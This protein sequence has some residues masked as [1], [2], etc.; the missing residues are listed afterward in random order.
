[1]N[2]ARTLNLLMGLVLLLVFG[3]LLLKMRAVDIDGHNRLV[4]IL[5]QLKQV[6]SDWNVEVL[7]SKT[8]FN[9]SYD[10]V[11]GPLPRFE[12]LELA[13]REETGKVWQNRSLAYQQLLTQAADYKAT[14]E[15]KIAMIE[16]FKSQ[17]SILRN[18]SRFLPPATGELLETIDRSNLSPRA[19]AELADPLSAMLAG[20]MNYVLTPEEGLKRRVLERVASL[21]A[22]A[23]TAPQ[24]VKE[25][26]QLLLPHVETILREQDL[27][28][29]LL[30]D[31]IAMP[32]ALKLDQLT[33]IYVAEHKKLLLEQQG[34]RQWLIVLLIGYT[35]FLLALLSYV[36]WRLV[37]SHSALNL[38]NTGL[39]G[40]NRQLKESQMQLVQSEKMSALGQMVAGIAHEINTPLSYLKGTVE[41]LR[42]QIGGLSE[43]VLGSHKLTQMLRNRPSDQNELKSQFL[44]VESLTSEAVESRAMDDLDTLLQSSADGISQISEI[45]LNLKNFSRVDRARVDEYSVQDGLESTL[46]LAR[47]MLKNHVKIVRQYA[48][49]PKIRCS[50]SQ[51]NQVFLNLITNATQAIAADRQ[52][53]ITLRTVRDGDSGVR[54]E[55]QDTGAGIAPEVLPKIFDPFFTTK[56]V[57]EGTGLGLSIS[58]KIIEEHGGRILVDSEPGIGTVFSII[59]PIVGP[60][61]S[62]EEETEALAA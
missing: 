34:Y 11:A 12:S 38:A 8:G 51:I 20:V 53:T 48:E 59:L 47:N 16:R 42:E 61:V 6:D 13:L 62:S 52:G 50:P 37:R 4:G 24:E 45:V 54:V 43:M 35:T 39:V 1:M 25:Q 5:R 29:R 19:K 9:A 21:Q 55:I 17:N 33:D 57:G 28:E 14:M 58:Y 7:K 31:L 18:S 22:G 15:R 41:L 26:V 30:A 49:V 2:N 32:T 36:G 60:A 27:G 40:A 3:F 10:P 44:R 56:E 23:A 46:L